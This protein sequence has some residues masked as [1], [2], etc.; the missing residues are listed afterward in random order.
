[1]IGKRRSPNKTY[2]DL[3][4]VVIDSEETIYSVETLAKELDT[5]VDAIRKR[6]N[7]GLIPAHKNGRMWFILKSEYVRSLREK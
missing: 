1:M 7:R 5:S 2:E 3:K 4:Q 6:I